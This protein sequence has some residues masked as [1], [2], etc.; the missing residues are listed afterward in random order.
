MIRWQRQAWTNSPI[1]AHPRNPVCSDAR[2]ARP[3]GRLFRWRGDLF[4]PAQDCARRY[5]H[6]IVFNK[7]LRLDASSYEERVVSRIPPKWSPGLLATHT[8][9]RIGGL[10]V[11]DGMR[12]IPRLPLRRRGNA[13]LA[14]G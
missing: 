8:F 6:A 9:N 7:V 4:R 3:A 5:G 10:T 13:D 2:H 14:R 11:V 12:R 1:K